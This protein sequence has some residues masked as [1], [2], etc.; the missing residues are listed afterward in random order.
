MA[1]AGMIVGGGCGG[2]CAAVA[3]RKAGFPV[4]VFEAA[5]E[6]RSSGAGLWLAPNA[7]RAL[8]RLGLAEEALEKGVPLRR[9]GIRNGSGKVIR[10]MNADDLAARY[11]YPIL[12]ISRAAFMKILGDRIPPGSLRSGWRLE[13]FASIGPKIHLRFEGGR[14]ERGDFL[15]GADGIHSRVRRQLFPGSRLRSAGQICWRG[16]SRHRLDPSCA[17]EGVEIWEAGRL[18]GYSRVD[19]EQVYWYAVRNGSEAG[20]QAPGDCRQEVVRYFREFPR[21]VPHLI[22]ATEPGG[23]TRVEL[24]DFLPLRGWIAGR[25]ALLGDAAHAMT[26]NLGQGAGQAIEDA[27]ALAECLRL[28]P[29]IESAFAAYE[30]LRIRKARRIA[31]LSWQVGRLA[32]LENG[33]ARRLRDFALSSLPSRIQV[34][35]TDQLYRLDF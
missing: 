4:K 25:V 6:I 28:G 3:L 17:D 9:V 32:A 29:T 5:P 14:W 33:L 23:I 24:R 18:F 15:L 31:K 13:A 12:S 27:V 30:K 10:E 7:L 2:L 26:P 11:G 1:S 8:S 34:R 20:L 16:L 21:P 35:Q 19:A 22:E